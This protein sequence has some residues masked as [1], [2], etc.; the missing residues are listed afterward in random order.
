MVFPLQR[1]DRTPAIHRWRLGV[2]DTLAT[3]AGRFTVHGRD[4]WFDFDVR[5]GTVNSCTRGAA[6]KMLAIDTRRYRPNT[7]QDV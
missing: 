7:L 5:N 6:V 2:E 4:R 1:L 3:A